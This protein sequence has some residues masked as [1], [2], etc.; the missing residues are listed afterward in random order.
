[1]RD[2]YSR[3]AC[4]IAAT[5][6]S[7]SDGGLFVSR[8]P[9]VPLLVQF[10]WDSNTE[11]IHG[12]EAGRYWIEREETW[13]YFVDEAPLNSR[14]WVCQERYLSPRTMHFVATEVF[15]ECLEQK[16]NEVHPNGLPEW[17]QPRAASI[18]A[19]KL[20]IND[21]KYRKLLSP[22]NGL[23]PQERSALR[24]ELYS[25]WDQ[26]CLKYTRCLL[27]KPAD[28]LVAIQGIA[29]EMAGLLDDQSVAGLWRNRIPKDLCWHCDGQ[30][31]LP[32][33]LQKWR[34]PTWSWAS[35]E[36]AIWPFELYLVEN[37]S[38]CTDDQVTGSVSGPESQKQAPTALVR[39][40][41]CSP[42]K[43]VV[44]VDDLDIE[45]R[46]SG[47]VVRASL[48]IKCKLVPARFHGWYN[49]NSDSS[50]N[51]KGS[52]TFQCTGHKALVNERS[53]GWSYGLCL[54]A[55]PEGIE[56]GEKKRTA[57]VGSG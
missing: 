23:G 48:R 10:D 26:L 1:M 38:H 25:L 45:A 40:A 4:T 42:H 53:Y 11:K 29:Q 16:A 37:H 47:E 43:V 33:R 8:S 36:D 55:H 12:P 7:N 32:S 5:S 34:A 39:L 46:P 15:W 51:V 50:A 49:P 44:S 27:T 20:A 19:F 21:P 54:D 41:Q 24:E 22:D 30:K 2:V 31:I 57:T 14:A 3:S 56:T 35:V 52:L 6:S 28:K 13:H 18:S 17:D 9:G